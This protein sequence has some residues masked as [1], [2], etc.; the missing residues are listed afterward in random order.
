MGV[1]VHP[2][3]P[4]SQGKAIAAPL[5]A[6]PPAVNPLSPS[7]KAAS[8]YNLA[9]G[10]VA[11]PAPAATGGLAALTV[12]PSHATAKPPAASSGGDDDAMDG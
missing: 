5:P 12:A 11:K 10:A 8:A 3:S 9:G 7:K 2:A 1:S 4:P 6:P